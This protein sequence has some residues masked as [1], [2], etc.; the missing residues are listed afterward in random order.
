[1]S[2]GKVLIDDQFQYGSEGLDGI[3]KHD[4]R[5]CVKLSIFVKFVLVQYLN[6]AIR[7]HH[8]IDIEID[9]VE[10][11]VLKPRRHIDIAE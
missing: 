7:P 3:F 6:P 5:I 1:M 11:T 10:H 2:V 4:I 8:D 9:I